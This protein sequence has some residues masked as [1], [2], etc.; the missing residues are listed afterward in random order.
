MEHQTRKGRESESRPYAKQLRGLWTERDRK[1]KSIDKLEPQQPEVM[2]SCLY[3]IPNRILVCR[4]LHGGHC[5]NAMVVDNGK[6]VSLPD[7]GNICKSDGVLCDVTTYKLIR[8]KFDDIHEI[9]W[10]KKVEQAQCHGWIEGWVK[11][12]SEDEFPEMLRRATET[13]LSKNKLGIVDNF[14]L[15]AQ[16]LLKLLKERSHEVP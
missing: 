16:E 9:P 1:E 7:K 10:E 11:L 3:P 13:A 2:T 6:C 14:D 15:I 8:E 12:P 5:D 4:H